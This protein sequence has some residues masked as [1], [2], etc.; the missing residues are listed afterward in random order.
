LLL[1]VVVFSEVPDTLML[2]GSTLIIASGLFSLS[3]AR[4]AEVKPS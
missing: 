1:G 3:R 2:L 4:K